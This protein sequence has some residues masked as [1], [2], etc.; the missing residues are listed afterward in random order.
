MQGPG[1][2]HDVACDPRGA[3][4]SPSSGPPEGSESEWFGVDPD[5]G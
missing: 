3:L 4:H 2:D 1:K 5:S